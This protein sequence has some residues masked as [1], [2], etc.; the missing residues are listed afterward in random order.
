MFNKEVSRALV[1]RTLLWAVVSSIVMSI[2]VT[3][4]LILFSYTAGVL[5]EGVQYPPDF[6]KWSMHD[7]NE[8]N[9]KNLELLSGFGYVR[10]RMKHPVASVCDPPRGGALCRGAQMPRCFRMRSMSC[11]SSISAMTFISPSQRAQTRGSTS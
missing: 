11:A 4:Y 9:L 3:A 7:Q 5:K 1:R 8:W 6:Y 10:E 2:V